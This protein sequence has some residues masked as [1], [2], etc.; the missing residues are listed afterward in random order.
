MSIRVMWKTKFGKCI[1]ISPSGYKVYQNLLYRWLTLGSEAWQTVINRYIPR[2]P[3]LHY[4]QM[5]TLMARKYPNDCC[6]LGLGGAGIAHL[7]GAQKTIRSIVAVESSEE[8]IQI[9]KKFFMTD[10]IPHFTITHQNARDFVCE[11]KKTF[12]HMLLDLYDATH[13]PDECHSMDFFIHCK[14]Q[15]TNDGF[16]A[17]N[18]ANSQEQWALVQ[19]IKKQFPSNIIIP[20]KKCA[21][22][23]V[24]VSK[25]DNK[26][27]FIKQVRNTNEIKKISWVK[28]WGYVAEY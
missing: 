7:L 9:A 19:L 22:I 24:I 20:I 15:L 4:L 2:R 27:L 18:L 6:L 26:D 21:N 17:V 8:V 11:N 28:D 23:V 25:N 14:K 3:G 12:Q 16:L 1:Y 13:F 5:L 10:L